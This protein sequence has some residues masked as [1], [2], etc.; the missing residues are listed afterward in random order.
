MLLLT[1]IIY[2]Y[3]DCFAFPIKVQY[4]IDFYGNVLTNYFGH[5]RK[6]SWIT[7]SPGQKT[8]SHRF[9]FF[10][11]L[12]KLL[13]CDGQTILARDLTI[14]T[15][16][17]HQLSFLAPI[18][19]VSRLMVN[20]LVRIRRPPSLGL[21][22]CSSVDRALADWSGGHSSNPTLIICSLFNP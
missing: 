15:Q 20:V 7:N 8:I 16:S 1:L 10:F 21:E 12:G 22:T 18:L 14:F 11:A 17:L 19:T 5:N 2:F 9:I 13:F 6:K 4:I 3:L